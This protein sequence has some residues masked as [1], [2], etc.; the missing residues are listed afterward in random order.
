MK[1]R[2]G[3]L[4]LHGLRWVVSGNQRGKDWLFESDVPPAHRH[5]HTCLNT[6]PLPLL[7]DFIQIV[8]LGKTGNQTEDNWQGRWGHA[9]DTHSFAK[10]VSAAGAKKY[11]MSIFS[12]H[13]SREEKSVNRF[14][15]CC[16]AILANNE[17]SF[18]PHIYG[19]GT[20]RPCEFFPEGWACW[21][22]WLCSGFTRHTISLFSWYSLGYLC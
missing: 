9:R 13:N 11:W 5:A 19:K 15:S 8:Q 17:H 20:A 7:Y 22:G 10:D 4:N 14:P 3:H 18:Y 21:R 16:S 12:A 2:R 6:S 1:W